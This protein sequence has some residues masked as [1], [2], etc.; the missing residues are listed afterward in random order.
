MNHYKGVAVCLLIV[1]IG[2]LIAQSQ[3]YNYEFNQS[4]ADRHV[5]MTEDQQSQTLALQE[6]Q[7]ANT[8]QAEANTFCQALVSNQTN[9]ET[10]NGS[11]GQPIGSPTT[12]AN[13]QSYFKIK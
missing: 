3:R 1:I 4:Q 13:C 12:I 11:Y 9:T 8:L 2:F 5:K 6:N 7:E 10:D